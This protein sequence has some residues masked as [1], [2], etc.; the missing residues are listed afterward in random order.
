MVSFNL[1][2]CE[3]CKREM[4][5]WQL[6]WHMCEDEMEYQLSNPIDGTKYPALKARLDAL[7][8]A[9]QLADRLYL[10][11][12]SP[13]EYSENVGDAIRALAKLPPGPKPPPRGNAKEVA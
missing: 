12:H 6:Q 9:A 11:F 10:G 8:E 3:F 7:E 4:T 1:V 2:P 5:V 13:Y